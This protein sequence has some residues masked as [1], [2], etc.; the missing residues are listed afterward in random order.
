MVEALDI[1]ALVES[2]EQAASVGDLDGAARWLRE[3]ADLQNAKLGPHHPDLAHTLN[4]LGVVHERLAQ[5]NDA[6]ACYRRAH[7]IALATLAPD[8]PFV[9]TSGRNLREFCAAHGR[10]PD[11]EA[12]PVLAFTPPPDVTPPGITDGAV[13]LQPLAR[14]PPL[15]PA[16]APPRSWRRRLTAALAVALAALALFLARVWSESRAGAGF[17]A[18][19]KAPPLA[20]PPLTPAP[21][22][23]PA[24]LPPAEAPRPADVA[25]S[26][27]TPPPVERPAAR[28]VAVGHPSVVESRVCSRLS[29]T[30]PR[31]WECEGVSASADAGRLFFYTRLKSANDTIVQHRWYK[32][33]RLYQSVD[34]R[35]SANTGSGY[36]T[37]SRQTVTPARAGDWRVELRAQDGTLLG[38]ERFTVLSRRP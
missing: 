27:P 8:H 30:G 32:G 38:E 13:A 24:P 23:A 28:E 22:A 15:A 21:A 19:D 36:R 7:A 26:E 16:S 17:T 5:L 25:K 34:L 31:G 12:P 14:T 9:E 29:T 18:D 2:A 4:N 10:T 35:V 37:F 1:R 3:A 11:L 6:E 20:S 33:D